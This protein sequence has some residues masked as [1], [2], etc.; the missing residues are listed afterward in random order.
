VVPALLARARLRLYD[1]LHGTALA[2]AAVRASD[3]ED[4]LPLLAAAADGEL[5]AADAAWADP[6]VERCA[7]CTRTIRAMRDA[8]ATY[9]SWS[10][11]APP[12]WLRAA[13]LAELEAQ[14]PAVGAVPRPRLSATVVSVTLVMAAS[15]ALLVGSAR[16]LHQDDPA[17]GGVRLAETVHSMEL[18][19]APAAG[20]NRAGHRSR[21]PRVTAGRRPVARSPARTPVRAAAWSRSVAPH[22]APGPGSHLDP[23]PSRRAPSVAPVIVVPVARTPDPVTVQAP[24]DEAP[25]VVDSASTTPVA[26]AA[27]ASADPPPGEPPPRPAAASLPAPKT[28]VTAAPP[29]SAGSEDDGGRPPCRPGDGDSR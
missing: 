16:S 28:V 6:H 5:E 27:S 11:A 1:E 25:G 19:A 10:P 12:S 7:T 21:G 9:A 23:A 13:T 22:A 4:V 24:P 29:V 14:E 2:A 17:P 3:C 26:A 20:P 18:A 15:A 8:A